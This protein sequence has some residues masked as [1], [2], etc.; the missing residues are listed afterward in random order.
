VTFEDLFSL[1]YHFAFRV[2]NKFKDDNSKP[3]SINWEEV[4]ITQ[5]G[6]TVEIKMDSFE[7]NLELELTRLGDMMVG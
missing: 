6:T 2:G 3:G 5:S 7:S 1:K 4:A